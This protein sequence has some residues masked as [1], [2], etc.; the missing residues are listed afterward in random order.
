L[1]AIYET[2]TIAWWANEVTF[3]DL[4]IL[5]DEVVSD[6]VW[7]SIFWYYDR[8]LGSAN[9]FAQSAINNINDASEDIPTRQGYGRTS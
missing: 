6:L 8:Q 5:I 1:Y 9:T 7:W 4:L 3:L 2:V